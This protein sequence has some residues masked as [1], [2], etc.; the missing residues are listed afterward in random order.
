MSLVRF[1][2]REWQ[3]VKEGLHRG[4]SEAPFA[5]MGPGLIELAHP[6]VE[7]GLQ[8]IDRRIE[9]LAECDAIELVKHGL[10]ESLDDAV[11]L[12]TLGLGAGVVD[13]LDRE[14]ELVFVTVVGPA[15]FGSPVGE[16]ALQE[17]T[18]LLEEGN[19]PV[20]EEVSG[21]Q[22]RL[23]VVELGEA[24]LGVGVD[25]GLLIDA[26]DPFESPDIEGV[27]GAAVARAFRDKFAMGLLVGLGLFQG[28]DLRLGQD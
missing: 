4:L 16:H 6:G 21:G 22:R 23:A 2:A 7:V 20:V 10:V 18:V 8:L 11:G 15:E 24:D 13:V 1:F 3:G 19:D 12:W 9:L 25:E 14:I 26:P 17:N 27:L 28:C 5:L